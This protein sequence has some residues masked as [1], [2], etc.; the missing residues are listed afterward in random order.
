[1]TK[2]GQTE[3]KVRTLLYDEI[4]NL[5]TY[6]L[7]PVASRLSPAFNS[8]LAAT[9]HCWKWARECLPLAYRHRAASVDNFVALFNFADAYLLSNTST[10]RNPAST[11]KIPENVQ[12]L[13]TMRIFHNGHYVK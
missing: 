1:M 7:F 8:V 2:W 6:L 11:L 10:M 9:A 13:S 5:H 4:L 3:N 12:N